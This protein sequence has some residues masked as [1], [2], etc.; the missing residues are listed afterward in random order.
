M[1]DR[2][3][4]KHACAL[5]LFSSGFLLLLLLASR[6]ASAED[7]LNTQVA[8]RAGE[9]SIE[10]QAPWQQAIGLVAIDGAKQFCTG[11]LIAQDKVVTAAHCLDLDLDLAHQKIGAERVTFRPGAAC[12]QGYC[13]STEEIGVARIVEIGAKTRHGTIK[14]AAVPLDWVILELQKSVDHAS[15]IDVVMPNAIEL[16]ASLAK[17][18]QL[19]V[20]G[21]G[22]TR[23]T[24]LRAYKACPYVDKVRALVPRRF[25]VLVLGCHIALGDSGGPI[26]LVGT[27]HSPQLIGIL[28]GNGRTQTIAKNP[29]NGPFETRDIAVGASAENFPA[30]LIRKL[31][32]YD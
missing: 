28:S 15:I 10:Q 27:G 9:P 16:K 14:L 30:D 5:F 19:V 29:E 26:L 18:D 31:N 2:R 24:A 11:T 21:Y 32:A 6:S 7:A 23:Y 20:G 1:R 12:G 25:K 8:S 17:G 13:P 3:Q 22:A 4:S